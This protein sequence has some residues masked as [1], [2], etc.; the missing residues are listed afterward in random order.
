M[1]VWQH[2]GFDVRHFNQLFSAATRR[3]TVWFLSAKL[4]TPRAHSVVIVK[5]PFIVAVVG[6][7]LPSAALIK[8][9][10]QRPPPRPLR[11]PERVMSTRYSSEADLASA[12]HGCGDDP[13]RPSTDS[14]SVGGTLCGG[15]C[16]RRTDD[17]DRPTY[18]CL[19]HGV[20]KG[21]RYCRRSLSRAVLLTLLFVDAEKWA[22]Y[23]TIR[24]LRAADSGVWRKC[25]AS[26]LWL[27]FAASFSAFDK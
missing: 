16:R 10:Q 13:K 25:F 3:C 21:D 15:R 18:D 9:P 2:S 14:I 23:A 6:F 27:L 19:F 8:L 22:A 4:P 17:D 7:F 12:I 24:T 11:P 5:S 1:C 26:K 20:E